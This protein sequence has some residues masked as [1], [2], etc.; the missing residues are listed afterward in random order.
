MTAG[1]RPGTRRRVVRLCTMVAASLAF[2]VGIFLGLTDLTSYS[3]VAVCE[4]RAAHSVPQLVCLVY[5]QWRLIVILPRLSHLCAARLN[6]FPVSFFVFVFSGPCQ[7][8][9]LC[10]ILV[11]WGS[12]AWDLAGLSIELRLSS[13]PG[14]LPS[15]HGGDAS[16]APPSDQSDSSG[17]LL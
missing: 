16:V 8:L 17:P 9:F 12:L 14:G 7:L 11:V 5:R 3:G 6:P 10:C 13:A 2:A 1:D 4:V 15:S